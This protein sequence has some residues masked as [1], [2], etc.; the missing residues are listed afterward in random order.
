MLGV[1]SGMSD[2]SGGCIDPV[3]L[4]HA[5]PDVRRT[6]EYLLVERGA[7]VVRVDTPPGTPNGDVLIELRDRDTILTITRDRGQWMLDLQ[8]DGL[9]RWSLDL[10][11]DTMTNRTEWSAGT[12]VL[13]AQ[14]PADVS[15]FEWLPLAVD[16]LRSTPDAEMRLAQAGEARARQHFG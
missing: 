2:G 11:S 4:E 8:V 5:T 6:A 10:I 3:A 12:G 16:W 14:L 1:I 9:Q 15:W 7:S 13:P